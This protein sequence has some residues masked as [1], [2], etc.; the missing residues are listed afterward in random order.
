MCA[1][2][3]DLVLSKCLYGLELLDLNRIMRFISYWKLIFCCYLN[4]TQTQLYLKKKIRKQVQTTPL[5]TFI[6][7]FSAVSQKIHNISFFHCMCIAYDMKKNNTGMA[8]FTIL[9]G[10]RDIKDLGRVV[11]INGDK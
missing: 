7:V 9:R 6:I 8:R 4:H 2:D 10:I 1:E 11:K 5:K 3:A